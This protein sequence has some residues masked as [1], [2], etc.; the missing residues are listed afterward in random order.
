M[1]EPCRILLVSGSLRA[2]STNTALLRTVRAV[3]AAPVETTLDGGLGALPLFN[4]DDD[5][6]GGP[7]HEAVADRRGQIGEAD[8]VLFAAPEYAGALPVPFVNLLDWTVGGGETYL[9]PVAYVNVSSSPTRGYD[10]MSSPRTILEKTGV[11]LVSAACVHLPV[12]RTDVGA[13]GLVTTGPLRAGLARV[14]GVL[15]RHVL[16][17]RAATP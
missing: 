1:A 17:A 10:A 16:D 8:A 9:K 7:L 3:A 5:Q 12:H 14:A 11:D 6:E 2:G 13:D 15:H 4:P